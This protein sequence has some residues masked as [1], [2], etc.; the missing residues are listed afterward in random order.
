VNGLDTYGL[1][2]VTISYDYYGV[3]NTLLFNPHAISALFGDNRLLSA[4]DYLG[5]KRDVI[6]E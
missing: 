1:E 6:Q 5:C 3:K 2:W 4:Y